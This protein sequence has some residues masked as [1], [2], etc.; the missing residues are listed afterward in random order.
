MPEG[1]TIHRLA[2]RHAKLLGGQQ[3]RAS[4]PQGRFAGGAELIDGHVLESTDAWGKHLFH[5]YA[6][7]L[8]LHVHLG[9]YGKFAD[10]TLPA[11]EP[12]GALRLRLQGDTSWLD[13]RGPITCDVI[14]RDEKAAVT[15]ALGPDPLR[16]GADPGLAA[17]RLARSRTA[18][19]ALLMNQ[20]VLAGVG[21]V[22]RAEILFRHGV[23]PYLAG[24]DL[25]PV[26]WL[27]MWEDLVRLMRHG[28]RTGRIITTDPAD[29][30]RASGPA[31]QSDA[32][33]VYR[34]TGQPCRRCDTPIVHAVMVTRNLFWCPRCQPEPAGSGLGAGAELGVPVADPDPVEAAGE[35]EDE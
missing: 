16:P 23:H 17:A 9:L 7:D 4:S 20:T 30:E 21:N 34:R 1:H 32:H 6:R 19:G 2:R 15:A 27:D 31:R 12:R 25:D 29:R 11:P 33:Y 14:T 18:L 10:G 13:L 35:D 24:R 26:V 3:L 28:V 22:Y 8:I 5:R